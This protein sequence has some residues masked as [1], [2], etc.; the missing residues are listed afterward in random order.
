[1]PNSV[2]K[3]YL[4]RYVTEN[5]DLTSLGSPAVNNKSLS[6]F[7]KVLSDSKNAQTQFN[8]KLYEAFAKKYK[9]ETK[10]LLIEENP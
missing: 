1:M 8:G 4:P 10:P 6:S 2:M 5:D 3:N 7:Q 9:A